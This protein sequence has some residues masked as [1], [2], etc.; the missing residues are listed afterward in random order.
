MLQALKSQPCSPAFTMIASVIFLVALSTRSGL[1]FNSTCYGPPY[2]G[3]GP[4]G[5]HAPFDSPCTQSSNDEEARVCCGYSDG[6]VCL[7]NGLCFVPANNTMMQGS[8]TD[9]TWTSPNCPNPENRCVG[10][11]FVSRLYWSALT[12]AQTATFISATPRLPMYPH[13]A[14]LVGGGIA[15][16]KHSVVMKVEVNLLGS[17]QGSSPISETSPVLQPLQPPLRVPPL[18]PPLRS[19]RQKVQAHLSQQKLLQ[20][21]QLHRVQPSLLALL[22]LTP[23][24][25]SLAEIL[26]R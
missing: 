24:I 6:S 1:T 20:M 21:R 4:N 8:C 7:T 2:D 22:R 5:P 10:K 18:Q 13:L 15:V 16:R 26:R 19:P 11:C 9:P 25:L 17:S 14:M 3:G 12:R 23:N